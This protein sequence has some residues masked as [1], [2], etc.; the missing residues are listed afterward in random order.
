MDCINNF[1]TVSKQLRNLLEENIQPKTQYRYVQ[2]ANIILLGV[3]T[4]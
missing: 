1:D 2:R 3:V 4:K